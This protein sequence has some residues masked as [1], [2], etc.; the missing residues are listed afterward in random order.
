MM[1]DS[2]NVK[3]D[4]TYSRETYYDIIEKGREAMDRMIDLADETGHPRAYE[5]LSGLMKNISDVTDRLMELQKSKKDL[6]TKNDLPKQLEDSRKTTNNFF[7][8]STADLQKMINDQKEILDVTDYEEN[9][10]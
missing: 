8:G 2:A 9:G 4:F 7:V 10:T 6:E 5:A 1:T 3:D